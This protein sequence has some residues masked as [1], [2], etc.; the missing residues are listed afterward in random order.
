MHRTAT[1]RCIRSWPSSRVAKTDA[2][3]EGNRLR[4]SVDESR[5]EGNRSAPPYSSPTI[6]DRPQRKLEYTSRTANGSGFTTCVTA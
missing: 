1:S 2:A 4:V 3:C 5:R 6:C